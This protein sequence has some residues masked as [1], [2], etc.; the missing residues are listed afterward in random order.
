MCMPYPSQID[1]ETIVRTAIEMIEEDGAAAL[2]LGK[3]AKA[4]GVRTLSLYRYVDSRAAL[5]QEVNQRTLQQLFADFDRTLS[6]A[7]A[8][9]AERLAA[10]ASA[11]RGYAQRHSNLYV[12]AMIAEPTITR[13]DEDLLVQMVLPLQAIMADISGGPAS[14]T[15]LRGFLALIHGF[16]ML[17]VHEQLQRGGNLD[18]AFAGSVAAYLA[19]WRRL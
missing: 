2:T 19:G 17:E 7:P 10:V 4:L 9:P 13:P 18:E 3:L 12:Q 8:G 16:I 5:L 6:S 15:A 11:Q 14:L 1:R